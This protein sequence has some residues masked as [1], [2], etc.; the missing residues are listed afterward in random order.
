MEPRTGCIT[1]S[2]AHA[3]TSA[4]NA[5]PES[6]TCVTAAPLRREDA[7]TVKSQSSR[8]S[9]EAARLR[10]EYEAE[11]E[12]AKV[13]ERLIKKKLALEIAEIEDDFG[14]ANDGIRSVVSDA[15]RVTQW[16][17]TESATQHVPEEPP[18]GEGTC[19]DIKWKIPL[20]YAPPAGPPHSENA[21][22]DRS[23]NIAPAP[24]P[25]LPPPASEISHLANAIM[26][27]S[28]QRYDLPEFDGN[29]VDWLAYKRAFEN[30]A[31]QYTSYQNIVRLQ[32][33]LRGPAK[34]AVEALLS[35]GS[36]PA[37]VID[38]L[39][40][41]FGHPNLLL[42][43]AIRK[44]RI[45]PRVSDSGAEL[46]HMTSVVR[47]CVYII[48]NIKADGYLNNP[49]MTQEI[50]GKLS[51]MQRAQYGEFVMKMDNSRSE[52]L[53]ISPNLNIVLEF[54]SHL[55]RASSYYLPLNTT[56]PQRRN[57]ATSDK[58]T[59]RDR[60]DT[61]RVHATAD[62]SPDESMRSTTP[63][64]SQT[65][66]S[67]NQ[68]VL[69][70]KYH[71]L[72]ECRVFIEKTSDQK[73]DF[74]KQN[75]LCFKCLVKQHSRYQCH[76]KRCTRC[77]ASHHELLHFKSNAIDD[78]SSD[79]RSRVRPTFENAS[80]KPAGRGALARA[81]GAG[82]L[83]ARAARAAPES[84]P[85]AP[86][87]GGR[88]AEV[89]PPHESTVSYDTES[90][91]SVSGERCTKSLLK[92]LPVIITVNNVDRACYALLDDGATVSIIDSSL[93]YDIKGVKIPL[94][95][96]SAS[97]H[98]VTDHDSC[99]V[100]A[101][102]TGPNGVRHN[103]A[104]RTMRNVDLPPQNVPARVLE[105]NAHLRDLGY[106]AMSDIK[107]MLLIGQDNW[108]LIVNHE[109]R[110][111]KSG[112]PVASL[113]KLGWVVH[114]PLGIPESS[115]DYVN[116]MTEKSD[117]LYEL[118]KRQFELESLGI[119]ET[120]R[121]NIEHERANEILERT[122]RRVD[123]G[124]E[125]GLL[126][127]RDEVHLPDNYN[128]A[129]KR[130][131]AVEN[132]MDKNPEYA[133]TYEK[134]IDRLVEEK[135]A[136]KINEPLN[137]NPVW[138]LP[139]FGVTNPNKPGKLRLV[140]DAAAKSQNTCLN[141]HLLAGPD[142]LNSLL[143]VL[144]KFRI[145]PIAYTADIADCFLRIKIRKEDR[146][147]QLFLWRGMDRAREPDSYV[148]DSMIFGAKSS[149]TSANFV[150]RKN[151]SEFKE[152]HP[153]A[154]EA[155]NRNH[156]MDDY[157]DSV[158]TVEVARQ[159]IQDV[160]MIHSAGG[161][162]IRGWVTNSPELRREL[163]AVVAGAVNFD[164]SPSSSERTLGMIWVPESDELAFDLSFKRL[165]PEIV[166]G[167]VIP[168]KRD[169]L[170]FVMS[171]FDP[172]GIL[173]AY[174]IKSKMLLQ[175]IWRSGIGWD[176]QLTEKDF[177]EW[178]NWL[179][180]IKQLPNL[181]VPRWYGLVP[182]SLDLHVFGDAGERGYAAV[183][184][185]VGEDISG[186]RAV[187]M[188]AGK[189][190]VAPLKVVSVPRLELQAAVLA[191]RLASM[192]EKELGL[193]IVRRILW[194]DS[195]TVLKWIHSD[196]RDFQKFVSHRLAEI[197]RKSHTNEW[198]WCPT[199]EN[200]A[201]EAT[202]L[203][204]PTRCKLWFTGP[205]F[206]GA[207]EDQWPVNEFK[208]TVNV[209][210]ER[211][212]KVHVIKQYESLVDVSRFS[213]WVRAVR[214]TARVIAF[215]GM[216]RKKQSE[217][218]T[219]QNIRD[220]EMFLI[221]QAQAETFSEELK[222]LKAG[223]VLLANS[224]IRNLD[225]FIHQ[226]ENVMRVRGRLS[227][228]PDL[229][230]DERHPIILDGHSY[231]AQL[232]ISHF[233]KRVHHANHETVINC[234]RERFWITHLRRT[235]KSVTT[236]CQFCRVR[237]ALPGPPKMADLPAARLTNTRRAFVNCGIDY[238]GPMEVSIGRRCEKRWGIIFTCMVTRAVYLDLAASLSADSAIMAIRRF[239]ARRGEPSIMFSDRGTNFV[240]AD[241]ELKAA[242][243]SLDHDRIRDFVTTKGIMWR[244]NSPASP[245]MGGSWE[246][247]IRTV[248]GAL[249]TVLKEQKPRE[250]ILLT[251][252]AEVEMTLNSRPLTYVNTDP[253]DPIALTP[254]HLL[255][256]T[257]SGTSTVGS[258][259]ASDLNG[260]K[261]WRK[262]QILADM[263][264][265]RWLKEYVPTLQR[266]QK[267]LN[268]TQPIKVGDV[269]LILI[270]NQP[271]NTWPR[272][273]ISAVHP[274]RDGIIRIVTIKTRTGMLTRPVVKVAVLPTDEL[275]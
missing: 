57:H 243:R 157:L 12:M 248:K 230:F 163:P 181:R 56:D 41:E 197:D 60:R 2:K 259:D 32:K 252:L 16:L 262:A 164:K 173:S 101:L 108:E 26:A 130:L 123:G 45:L 131:R 233:H 28:K 217:S 66:S 166:E 22:R 69:C 120:S 223:T 63:L 53:R 254:N 149:P 144:L 33:S 189:A 5:G 187:A 24:A 61:H 52:D 168:T 81:G 162:E 206:L 207:P 119:V 226:E 238:F 43:S 30:T 97:G 96:V 150:L 4:E 194:S 167:R 36:A 204:W 255:L 169:F 191:C 221:R 222:T 215:V 170:K 225:P 154:V 229:T 74:V 241:I 198:R 40:E 112:Q 176:Q 73:W 76:A 129:L 68:C 132:K 34:S 138:W 155:I 231:T 1:R 136:V 178:L 224:R 218:L 110:Q 42:E 153:E 38:A 158:L 62:I 203:Y 234:I 109:I 14:D 142:L 246:R 85:A 211:L 79:T 126:W 115:P 58:S 209:D 71:S 147:A 202:K 127:T 216:C 219:G 273:V 212:Q 106:C 192:V 17:G 159:R 31:V 39:E 95:I 70:D 107:P 240:R 37:D 244:F 78:M 94:K 55:S 161:F 249:K 6:T 236:A 89:L 35:T 27:M 199:S 20:T 7:P 267:W 174:T 50:L 67:K 77:R 93:C 257:A 146:G 103:I 100:T 201:D 253:D 268:E 104:L 91:T 65:G 135:Y 83:R 175:T 190:R 184:Y 242:M 186:R 18:A 171:I 205:S 128:A 239:C 10:A 44:I 251:L 21:R 99:K 118:V 92:V 179:Q 256:G 260:R 227:G 86:A 59:Y 47:N 208:D 72:P 180:D 195:K 137:V 9:R 54:L 15:E 250:E 124:W 269:V 245:H 247:L 196:P 121:K 270:D 122:S 3:S 275:L 98:I 46:R 82:A 210:C 51:P 271:R 265:R 172:L 8:S 134:Q 23:T 48:K 13:Q 117:D 116:F 213:S 237:R 151:A 139:H 125:V 87:H 143:G 214:A 49:Q 64:L 193:P 258:F 156:Y 133:A 84:A 90:V 160:S 148:M 141:D 88:S 220:A 11:K 274:G 264:W 261:M 29:P 200:P 114:G 235:V 232:I 25:P 177:N 113:T 165:P 75:K 111:G 105:Q 272:G 263:F 188:V 185:L 145:G 182:S 228:A 19:S 102:I 152:S 183:A 80:G 266:R 140:F